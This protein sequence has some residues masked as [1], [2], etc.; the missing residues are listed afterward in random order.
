VGTAPRLWH[1]NLGSGLSY[2]P[3]K[4]L[5]LIYLHALF[6][7]DKDDT[8]FYPGEDT[9]SVNLDKFKEIEQVTAYLLVD[10]MVSV[11]VHSE[12]GGFG[13]DTFQPEIFE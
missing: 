1:N 3:V 4:T 11:D 7:D 6:F 2:R 12:L 13:N 10:S 9:S 8:V 5:D